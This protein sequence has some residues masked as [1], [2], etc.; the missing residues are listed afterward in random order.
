[1]NPEKR[2]ETMDKY[3]CQVCGYVYDPEQGDPE[4]DIP[5]GTSFDDLPEDWVCPVCGA[6]KSEF[7]KEA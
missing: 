4:S 6:G 3:V 7:E 2:R 5:A 1:M